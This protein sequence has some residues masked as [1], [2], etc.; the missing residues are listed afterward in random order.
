MCG[1]ERFDTTEKISFRHQISMTG[2]LAILFIGLLAIFFMKGIAHFIFLTKKGVDLKIPQLYKSNNEEYN[3][4]V[5]VYIRVFY[6]SILFPILSNESD[7]K[8]KLYKRIVNSLI[9][10]FYITFIALIWTMNS[11]SS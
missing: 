4:R 9:F 11:I 5:K 10:L 2:E 6:S 7:D 3:K 8:L 1:V